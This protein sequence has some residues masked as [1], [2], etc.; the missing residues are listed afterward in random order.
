MGARVANGFAREAVIDV[1]RK[2][3]LTENCPRG[4]DSRYEIKPRVDS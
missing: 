4:L 1:T 2:V 3:A